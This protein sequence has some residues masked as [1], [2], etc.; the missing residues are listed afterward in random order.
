M[1]QDSVTQQYAVLKRFARNA[2]QVPHDSSHVIAKGQLGALQKLRE[3]GSAQFLQQ[4]LSLAAKDTPPQYE[5]Y[6]QAFSDARL[7]KEAGKTL[8]EF[9]IREQVTPSY[10]LAAAIL[11]YCARTKD[12]ALAAEVWNKFCTEAPWLQEGQP[13]PLPEPS[14]RKTLADLS[15][16]EL[17]SLPVWMKLPDLNP[18]LRLEEA[19]RWNVTRDVYLAMIRVLLAVPDRDAASNLFHI[20]EQKLLATP[21]PKVRPR[22]Q[23]WFKPQQDD[24]PWFPDLRSNRGKLDRWKQIVEREKHLRP[25]RPQRDAFVPSKDELFPNQFRANPL[26][27]RH[28]SNK[29]FLVY[30]Y[31]TAIR[32]SPSSAVAISF[33]EA[34]CGRLVGDSELHDAF[35]Q[36]SPDL[37]ESRQKWAT[38]AEAAVVWKRLCKKTLQPLR[39]P[40]MAYQRFL[41]RKPTTPLAQ[42][43]RQALDEAVRR[44]AV[45]LCPTAEGMVKALQGLGVAKAPELVTKLTEAHSRLHKGSPAES[46][47]RLLRAAFGK[48]SQN[49]SQSAPA[50]GKYATIYLNWRLAML[51]L[52]SQLKNFH[53]IFTSSQMESLSEVLDNLDPNELVPPQLKEVVVDTTAS[54]DL[55]EILGELL[56]H[57]LREGGSAAPLP[58]TALEAA[59]RD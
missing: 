49:A 54:A 7:T 48:A 29:H 35:V 19:N 50:V 5:H 10:E 31:L 57:L 59:V 23:N 2:L 24:P 17:Y 33:S 56:N 47:A 32:D 21:S 52:K 26:A 43:Q 13:D 3:T 53:D 14:P 16:L 6:L 38:T 36:L 46:R 15:L 27:A 25:H 30:S 51:K 28:L 55:C 18:N 8:W 12:I 44:C 41:K 11:T 40:L 42:R 45:L 22:G 4:C 37:R 58:G 34:L 9:I 1:L 39:R 20:L